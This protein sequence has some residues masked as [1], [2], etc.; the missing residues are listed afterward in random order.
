MKALDLKALLLGM[1]LYDLENETK[2]KITK[3]LELKEVIKDRYFSDKVDRDYT[4]NY[5]E[6]YFPEYY[7]SLVFNFENIEESEFEKDDME[8]ENH[9]EKN[10]IHHEKNHALNNHF[11]LDGLDESESLQHSTNKNHFDGLMN[12]K[13]P[14]KNVINHSL[15]EDGVEEEESKENKSNYRSKFPKKENFNNKN[16]YGFYFKDS[17]SEENL[18]KKNNLNNLSSTHKTIN[19]VA[20]NQ[21]NNHAEDLDGAI[22]EDHSDHGVV[23]NHFGGIIEDENIKGNH[24]DHAVV[25]NHLG[26]II[27]ENIK[28]F[29][30]KYELFKVADIPL[31]KQFDVTLN[32]QF[33]QIEN[34]LRDFK[35]KKIRQ[36]TLRKDVN[37]EQMIRNILYLYVCSCK[38]EMYKPG[39]VSILYPL[40][41][42][43][44]QGDYNSAEDLFRIE[45]NTFL[46]FIRIV[47]VL[48]DEI[49]DNYFKAT[50]KI[51]AR[52]KK[53]D[54]K[55]L[56]HFEK[57]E[58]N[59]LGVLPAWMLTLY[60]KDLEGDLNIWYEIFE[61]I[62]LPSINMSSSSLINFTYALMEFYRKDLLGI[63]TDMHLLLY[64]SDLPQKLNKENMEKVI[65]LCNKN[66]KKYKPNFFGKIKKFAKK[67][68]G[69]K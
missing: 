23:E 48:E 14:Q 42:L 12:S 2:N 27:E 5:L 47:Y 3:Y 67:T 62:F 59:L 29:S 58:I 32:K 33:Q 50:E 4:I 40:I 53:E 30:F 68:L 41:N 11:E 66:K 34:D 17:D 28:D 6:K 52:L 43:F 15:F 10:G 39:M 31:Q 45:V 46:S 49:S 1:N 16:N 54:S 24:L 21:M 7:S 20:K 65:S 37:V 56:K 26:E 69:V 64:F 55:L 18:D 25:E 9:V 22:I 35:F 61:E 51:I 38:K 44:I 36:K 63:K 60:T 8:L 19:Q 57:L 13:N